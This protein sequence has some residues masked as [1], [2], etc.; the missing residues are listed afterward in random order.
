MCEVLGPPQRRWLR[1]QLEAS[2]APLT[3]V[4]SGSVL[5]GSLGYKTESETCSGDDWE[6]R[7]AAWRAGAAAAQA[8][9]AQ[10]AGRSTAPGARH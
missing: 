2:R 3:I 6:V 5:A 4:A 10:P 1:Q 7:M 8:A 9:A